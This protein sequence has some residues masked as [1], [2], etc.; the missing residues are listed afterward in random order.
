MQTP[1]AI[2]R[3]S[4]EA[5]TVKVL[6]KVPQDETIYAMG[7]ESERLRKNG[8]VTWAEPSEVKQNRMV[9]TSRHIFWL[10]PQDNVILQVA[11]PRDPRMNRVTVRSVP[12]VHKWVVEYWPHLS[13]WNLS[14]PTPVTY[15]FYNEQGKLLETHDIANIYEYSEEPK[16]V[17][18][19]KG[20]HALNRTEFEGGLITA[21]GSPILTT[22][23][24]ALSSGR[25]YD[26]DVV[27]SVAPVWHQQW[28]FWAGM[29]AILG[30][31]A[32]ALWVLSK[33]Y[34]R[35][36]ALRWSWTVL[37]LL[38]GPAALLTFLALHRLPR[39]ARC[40]SC[41][42]MRLRRDERCTKCKTPWPAPPPTGTEIFVP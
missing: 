3:I 34:A 5:R 8:I 2:Y 13:Y 28:R 32:I 14:L 24:A 36:S 6:L 27:E 41:R 25:Y 7:V 4:T 30:V 26:W 37:G 15:C 18:T 23:A 17:L 29:S 40:P 10:S 35:P 1:H 20:I 9:F 21:V 39:W 33:V 38:F 16:S 11:L 19:Q 42:R 12:T 22:A 31:C